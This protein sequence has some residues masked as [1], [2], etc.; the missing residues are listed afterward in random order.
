MNEHFR[1]SRGNRAFE[2]SLCVALCVAVPAG[3]AIGYFHGGFWSALGI[4]AVFVFATTVAFAF[5]AQAMWRR[6]VREFLD[7]EACRLLIQRFSA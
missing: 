3:L 2:A 1:T 5:I 4:M 7:S 6:R